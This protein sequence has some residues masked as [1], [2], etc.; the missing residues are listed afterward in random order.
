M[1]QQPADIID[2]CDSDDD[3][4]PLCH[5]PSGRDQDDAIC[6]SSDD[7][8]SIAI[9]ETRPG[10]DESLVARNRAEISQAIGAAQISNVA[11]NIEPAAARCGKGTQQG[12]T[13][14]NEE[15]T[16]NEPRFPPLNVTVQR[17]REA[18]I[19]QANKNVN[20]KSSQSFG[21]IAGDH[22]ATNKEA[23]VARSAAAC[24]PVRPQFQGPD[25]ATCGGQT[26][27]PAATKDCSSRTPGRPR[28]QNS[29][30]NMNQIK[31]EVKVE[32]VHSQATGPEERDSQTRAIRA[33]QHC[34]R[35]AGY[36][37]ARSSPIGQR[38]VR[39]L[40]RETS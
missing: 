35:P 30:D 19:A 22:A 24:N 15:A 39:R 27:P 14:P 2:L 31:S 40:D 29:E 10:N 33:G 11:P 16:C 26:V 1:V 37:P 17:Q 6:L 20:E 4:Y 36:R 3:I 5:Q 12:N 7:D 9:D 38:G 13:V 21:G 28:D 34:R 18:T 25:I 23:M 32:E 8:E